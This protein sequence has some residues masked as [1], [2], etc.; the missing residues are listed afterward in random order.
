MTA[1]DDG[2]HLRDYFAGRV[3]SAL[4]RDLSAP[5]PMALDLRIERFGALAYALADSLIAARNA[6]AVKRTNDDKGRG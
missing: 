1:C 5:N 2:V 6:K 3:A 4:A